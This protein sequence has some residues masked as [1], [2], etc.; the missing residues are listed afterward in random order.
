LARSLRAQERAIE[1]LT[2]QARKLIAQDPQRTV[3][4]QFGRK[5]GI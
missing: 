1:R 2:R 3:L 4:V 5:Y